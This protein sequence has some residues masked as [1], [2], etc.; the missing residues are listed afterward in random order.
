MTAALQ[1]LRVL[2]L[3]RYVAGAYCA[4][5]LAAFGAE[6]IKVEPPATGRPGARRGAVSA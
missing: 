1:G 6:V 2:D 3:S 4:K 5:L